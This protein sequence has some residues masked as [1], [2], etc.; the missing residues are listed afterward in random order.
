V[1]GARGQGDQAL[2]VVIPL[3]Q[4]NL[5]TCGV[6]RQHADDTLVIEQLPDFDCRLEA[7]R[8]RPGHLFRVADETD[9]LS[10]GGRE[11]GDHRG[12]HP[13]EADEPDGALVECTFLAAPA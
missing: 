12:S 2:A 3:P 5:V 8:L 10:S 9:Y 1:D 7:E 11:V 4:N 6:I 13:A